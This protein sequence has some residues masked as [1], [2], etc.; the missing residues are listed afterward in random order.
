[1]STRPGKHPIV[2]TVPD[3]ARP[4]AG[5]RRFVLFYHSLIS[6]WNHGNAHFLRGV[7]AEL[8]SRGHQVVVMEPRNAWSVRNMMEDA[9]AKA[10]TGFRNAYPMLRTVRYDLNTLDLDAILDGADVV[11]VHEWNDHS[12]VANI[13]QH[14]RHNRNYQLLFHDTHHRIVSQPEQMAAYDLREYDGVLAFGGIIRDMY[15][16]R[17]F[18]ERA[19]AWHEAADTRVFY[20]LEGAEK[21]DQLI[22]IGNWGDDERSRELNEFF[23]QPCQRLKLAANAYGVRYPQA[24]LQVLADAGIRYHGWVPNY[25]AP[26]LFAAHQVTVH[27]PRRPYV[28]RLP[29]I[30]TIR[31]FEAMACG[32]PLVC[33]WWEDC[34]RLFRPGEDYLVAAN[35]EQ[36]RKHLRAVLSDKELSQSLRRSGLETIRS[37]HT[38]AHR[39]DELFSI[40]SEMENSGSQREALA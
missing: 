4:P 36:M 9:G 16:K 17:G 18:A 22:W 31:P 11:I 32:I 37:R 34:E 23:I 26:E 28:V 27:I 35:G 39:V 10:I 40:L 30:P 3:I 5:K 24:A 19:W 20:P 14:H 15:L 2:L 13:G 8:L 25:R 33:A 12:L 29:G 7:A 38:C 21:Q 6:C 1:M